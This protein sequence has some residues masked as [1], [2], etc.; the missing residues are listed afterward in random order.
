MADAVEAFLTPKFRA[1]FVWAFKPKPNKSDPDK[2][3]RYTILMLFPKGTDLAPLKKGF[4][5]AAKLTFGE[6]A[7]A[8][9]K[10][11]NFKSP[12]KDAL[13]VVNNEGEP[14]FPWAEG[15]TAIEAWSYTA[16]GIAG[17]NIDPSTGRVEIL[18]VEEDFYAGAWARAKVRPYAYDGRKKQQG[19]GINFDLVNIQKMADGEKLSTG[20]ARSKP[21]DDFQPIAGSDADFQADD[22]FAA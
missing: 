14:Y 4:Q 7:A 10:L 8:T 20:G 13:A 5:E 19:F 15:Y 9:T 6:K 16:P 3:P 21:E 11:P 22:E 2:K 12:F 17:P 1:A 18:T